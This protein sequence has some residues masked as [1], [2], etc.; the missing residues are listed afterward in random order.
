MIREIL[1]LL[2]SYEINF[3]KIVL[4]DFD[5]IVN[6]LLGFGQVNLL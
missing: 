1:D 4:P 2:Q 5:K 3:I 6:E